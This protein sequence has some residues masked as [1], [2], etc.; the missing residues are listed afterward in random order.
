MSFI[1]QN[2]KS[3]PVA[4]GQ[5]LLYCSSY[6]I[7]ETSHLQESGTASGGNVLAGAWPKGIRI[8]LKGR[9]TIS[10]EQV[11]Y[12]LSQAM[13][14]EQILSLTEIKFEH[15][16]LCSYTISDQQEIPEMTLVFY[17]HEKPVLIPQEQEDE[18]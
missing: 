16:M 14:T 17:S 4:I 13:L 9:L 18:T 8:T 6:Q 2:L 7:T 15:A 5:M 1:L 10:P 12:T 3:F 11:I